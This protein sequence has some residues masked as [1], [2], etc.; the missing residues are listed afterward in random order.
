VSEE[1][2]GSAAADASD[3]RDFREDALNPVRR[4]FWSPRLCGNAEFLNSV[5]L[6]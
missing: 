4:V 2:V 3:R 5:T 1:K 6:T